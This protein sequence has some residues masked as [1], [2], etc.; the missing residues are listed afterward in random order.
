MFAGLRSHRS[1]KVLPAQ[2]TSETSSKPSPG[3]C[4]YFFSFAACLWLLSLVCMLA[5]TSDLRCLFT[6][7][8]FCPA[9]CDVE[10]N[11]LVQKIDDCAVI[12]AVRVDRWVEIISSLRFVCWSV[13]VSGWRSSSFPHLLDFPTAV[14]WAQLWCECCGSCFLC[15]VHPVEVFLLSFRCHDGLMMIMLFVESQ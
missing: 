13:L 3:F 12:A 15:V 10:L 1:Q 11:V 5:A 2:P 7:P 6:L 8:P 9:C 14:S 4:K